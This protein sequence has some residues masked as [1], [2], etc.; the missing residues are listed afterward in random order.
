MIWVAWT[1][2]RHGIAITL[3]TKND[4]TILVADKCNGA[5]DRISH[6]TKVPDPTLGAI[7]DMISDEWAAICH[8][9]NSKSLIAESDRMNA[10]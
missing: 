1:Q 10:R 4:E 7:E 8:Q 5:C 2:C 3:N 9:P 6:W